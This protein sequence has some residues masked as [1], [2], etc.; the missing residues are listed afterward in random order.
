MTHLHTRHIEGIFTATGA[1]PVRAISIPLFPKDGAWSISGHLIAV[2]AATPRQAMTFFPLFTGMCEGGVVMP[3]STTKIQSQSADAKSPPA[4]AKSPPAD[5]GG[6][7]SWAPGAPALA[8]A[9]QQVE[10]ELAGIANTTIEWGWS[11]DVV[12]LALPAQAPISK[13]SAS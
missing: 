7:Q 1:A 12:V 11:F 6:A 13:P 8:V 4:D 9:G 3:N 2:N 5:G 10:I